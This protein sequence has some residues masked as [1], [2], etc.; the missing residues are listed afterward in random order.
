M[1]QFFVC[2]KNQSLTKM[3]SHNL[4]GIALRRDAIFPY[5]YSLYGVVQIE[6]CALKG[7]VERQR[8][9]F[10]RHQRGQHLVDVLLKAIE[11]HRRVV[12]ENVGAL[13][14]AIGNW[15]VQK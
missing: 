1:S 10:A 11:R 3:H 6:A 14:H 9:I 7:G 12:V 8:P 5:T 2:A 15:N 13:A 4:V